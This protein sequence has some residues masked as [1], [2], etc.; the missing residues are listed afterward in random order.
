MARKVR[1]D[2]INKWIADNAPGGMFR[3]GEKSKVSVWTIAKIK[4]GY[5][6]KKQITREHLADALDVTEDQLFP[7][8]GAKGKAS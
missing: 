5:V 6:P 3:L 7:L 2:I 8:V 4:T 1:K